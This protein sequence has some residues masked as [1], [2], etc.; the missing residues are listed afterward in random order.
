M[1]SAGDGTKVAPELVV[2]VPGQVEATAF[3]LSLRI[4]VPAVSV[5]PNPVPVTALLRSWK[6]GDRVKVNH[7]SRP[8]K[9]KEVLEHMKVTGTSR[10]NWPVLEFAGRI[11]WMRGIELEPEPEISVVATLLD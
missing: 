5:D 8:R 10:L 7:S 3:G 9:V 4:E 1:A 2:S 6:P 11:V